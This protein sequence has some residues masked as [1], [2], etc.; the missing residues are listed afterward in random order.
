MCSVGKAVVTQWPTPD[1]VAADNSVESV[2][3]EM[4]VALSR[5]QQVKARQA[6]S[7]GGG[8]NLVRSTHQDFAKYQKTNQ[9]II[10]LQRATPYHIHVLPLLNRRGWKLTFRAAY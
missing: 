5:L 10:P 1:D 3:F 6:S 4:A 7:L 2:R 9:P 8:V